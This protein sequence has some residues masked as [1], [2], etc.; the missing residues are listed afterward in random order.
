MKSLSLHHLFNAINNY[1]PKIRFTIEIQPNKFLDTNINIIT[2]DGK[3]ETS[4]YRKP[5]KLPTHWSSKT[6]KSYERNTINGDLNRAYR[7][8]MNFTD[9]K[10]VIRNKFTNAGF[11]PRFVES[12]IEQYEAKLSNVDDL[13]IPEFLF[14]DPKKFIL[15]ELPYCEKNED[16]SKRFI[17]KLKSFTNDKIDFAIKWSTKKVKQLFGTKDKNPHPACKIYEGICSCGEN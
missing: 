15:I 7:I 4:V 10:Q 13:I 1:H 8:G 17:Q 6:P 11:P 5:N 14:R 3:A 12:V 2:S 16:L 9:E